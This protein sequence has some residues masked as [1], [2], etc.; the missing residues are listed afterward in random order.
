M[1]KNKGVETIHMADGMFSILQEQRK[2]FIDKFGRE[3][4]PSDPV[5]F[6]PTS[7]IPTPLT[8]N[9]LESLFQDAL[10]NTTSAFSKN[11]N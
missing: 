2:A 4:G 8:E 11:D 10:L 3:P 1:K 5:F 7:D 9:K 6:D